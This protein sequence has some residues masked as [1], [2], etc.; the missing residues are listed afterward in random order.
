MDLEE[1]L[2]VNNMT[3]STFAKSHQLNYHRL[4]RVKQGAVTRDQAI[5][6]VFEQ[7][8]ITNDKKICAGDP[9]TSFLAQERVCIN[10]ERAGDIYC[11][12]LHQLEE[13]E[14]YL[15]Q[16]YIPYY[17]RVTEDYWMIKYDRE[18]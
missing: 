3:L 2:R 14:S 18:A 1:Y 16:H 17:V 11:Y 13:I 8:N 15:A 9:N 10:C 12:Y 7:L 4:F 5:K 6:R